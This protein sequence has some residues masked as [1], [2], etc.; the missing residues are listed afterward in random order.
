MQELFSVHGKTAITTGGTGGLGLSMAIALA[1]AGAD[2]VSIQL[3][4]DPRAG[5]LQEGVKAC[6]RKLTVFEVDVADSQKLRQC[7]ADIWSSGV[8]PDILL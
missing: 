8:V 7:F 2:I 1:E 5:L 4:N 3:P 6:G